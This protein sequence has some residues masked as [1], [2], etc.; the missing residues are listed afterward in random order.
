MLARIC[1]ELARLLPA[2]RSLHGPGACLVHALPARCAASQVKILDEAWQVP[3]P[4]ALGHRRP[5]NEELNA[6]VAAAR[7]WDVFAAPRIIL[8]TRL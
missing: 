2:R 6:V 5:K 8:S 3:V 1:V 4:R 7:G